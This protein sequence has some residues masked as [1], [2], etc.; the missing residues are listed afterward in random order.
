M[1][2]SANPRLP[3]YDPWL[4]TY[5]V[6][7]SLLRVRLRSSLRICSVKTV[8]AVVLRSNLCG[9]TCIAIDKTL[10]ACSLQLAIPTL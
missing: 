5:L 8:C 1:S 7:S 3:L 9:G 4:L 6:I 2:W 10:S